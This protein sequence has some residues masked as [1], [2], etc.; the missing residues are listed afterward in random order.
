MIDDGQRANEERVAKLRS[1]S[2]RRLARK[3]NLQLRHS[4][5]GY[6]LVDSTSGHV[7]GRRDLTL[8]E[9][10]G[11]LMQHRL[12]EAPGVSKERPHH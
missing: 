1:N 7:D 9:V 11:Y 5:S 8:D 12:S 4:D 10:E 3:S 6:S 2:L